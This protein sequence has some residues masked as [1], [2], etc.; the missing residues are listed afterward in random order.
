MHSDPGCHHFSSKCIVGKTRS[1]VS[2]QY[3]SSL[4]ASRV[5]TCLACNDAN[6]M[7]VRLVAAVWNVEKRLHILM[8]LIVWL[9]LFQSRE[10]FH[11]LLIC[12]SPYHINSN[13]LTNRTYFTIRQTQIYNRFEFDSW[14]TSSDWKTKFPLFTSWQITHIY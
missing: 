1:G 2:T 3:F 14:Q 7:S 9:W 5:G 6:I 10:C 8:K 13:S 12:H 4:E 11:I